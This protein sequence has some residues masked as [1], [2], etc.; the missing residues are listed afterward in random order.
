MF[1]SSWGQLEAGGSNIGDLAI[2]VAQARALSGTARLGVLSADPAET[3]RSLGIRGI[4]VRGGRLRGLVSGVLWSSAVVV[5]GGELVQDRS[6][7][8]YTPFNLLPLVLAR[9]FGRPAFCWGI[10]LG[11]GRE[12]APWTPGMIRRCVGF[13]R[14]SVVR[15]GPSGDLLERLGIPG[16]RILRGSD[17][18]FGLCTDWSAGPVLSDVLGAAPRDVSN[19]RGRLLPL[20]ARR[21][22]G[23]AGEPPDDAAAAWWASLLDD[24]LE[25]RGG[26]IRLF[27]FHT[28]TLS[29]SDDRVCERV[30][31]RMRCPGE[32]EIVRAGSLE[33][34]MRALSECRVML[35]APLHGA[36]L[37]VVCGPLPVMVPYSSKG[38]RFMK[39]AGLEE[40]LAPAGEGSREVLG[41]AWSE[42]G[43]AWRTLAA[44]RERLRRLAGL[45]P[46]AL[47]ESCLREAVA[48]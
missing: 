15:D 21:R 20:E 24:H 45:A 6:S 8:L 7:L 48:P 14:M 44:S 11:Q 33:D 18:A 13:A 38:P 31:E 26:M 29:N 23:L 30:R 27:A 3:E 22:M 39:E 16:H 9:L 28:G 34:F 36:I 5:G 41:R 4:S 2:L 43:A 19:R 42:A 40:F 1:T 12:L 46:G 25:K 35:T 17:A 47:F 37:S 10:G 32:V